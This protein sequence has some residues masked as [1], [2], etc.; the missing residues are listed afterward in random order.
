MM[1]VTATLERTARDGSVERQT[2]ILRAMAHDPS[3]AV[4]QRLK[5][6]PGRV[7]TIREASPFR[8]GEQLH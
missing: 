8:P 5:Y 2:V 1:R 4:G 6:G 7:W 3:R